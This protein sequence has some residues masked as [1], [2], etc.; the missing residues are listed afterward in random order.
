[1][2][3]APNRNRNNT[4]RTTFNTYDCDNLINS[5]ICNVHMVVMQKKWSSVMLRR[6]K[7]INIHQQ[8]RRKLPEGLNLYLTNSYQKM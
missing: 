5:K 8:T 7:S 6:R 1:M 2:R 4:G 3:R